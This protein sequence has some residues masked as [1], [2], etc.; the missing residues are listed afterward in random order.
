MQSNLVTIQYLE[1]N[2]ASLARIDKMA[3]SIKQIYI[4][5]YAHYSLNVTA[6]EDPLHKATNHLTDTLRLELSS[7]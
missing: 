3:F 1:S 6:I 4:Y 2:Q 7:L 5:I